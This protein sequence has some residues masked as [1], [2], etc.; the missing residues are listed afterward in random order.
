MAPT[1]TSRVS[2]PSRRENGLT[3]VEMLVVLAVIVILASI[4]IPLIGKAQRQAKKTRIEA[5]MQTISLGINQYRDTFGSLPP[6]D[7]QNTGFAVLGKAL[8]GMYDATTVPPFDASPTKVYKAGEC[9]LQGTSGFVAIVDSPG[10]N[11]G[12][13]TKW[14]P[15]DGYDG[16]DGPGTRSRMGLVGN[17]SVPQGKVYPPFVQTESLNV[18]GCAL[19]D[20]SGHP[21]LYFPLQGNPNIHLANG[22]IA[23]RNPPGVQPL[24]DANA[25]LVQFRQNNEGN[26]INSLNRLRIMLGD[27]NCNGQI[28][29]GETPISAKE[30]ILYSAGADGIYG[31]ANYVPNT[32]APDVNLAHVQDCDDILSLH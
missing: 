18:S 20:L 26:D 8:V 17:A 21:I 1:T 7:M 31:P 28:D 9:V 25:N 11:T 29:N 14:A 23:Q 3:L 27:L 6:V 5:D 13:P 16:A 19:D 15:F 2:A 4:A 22:Y 10:T 24:I 12:D 32:G 30:Y